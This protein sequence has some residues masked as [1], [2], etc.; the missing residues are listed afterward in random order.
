MQF[1]LLWMF[2]IPMMYLFQEHHTYQVGAIYIYIPLY[3]ICITNFSH[4]P[5]YTPMFVGYSMSCL[6]SFE[7]FLNP[8]CCCKNFFSHDISLYVLYLYIPNVWSHTQF[9][10]ILFCDAGLRKRRAGRAQQFELLPLRGEGGRFWRSRV[11]L[12]MGSC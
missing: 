7:A 8:N 5:V 3:H 12:G 2:K 10:L 1:P 6:S 4:F 11:S 9:Y